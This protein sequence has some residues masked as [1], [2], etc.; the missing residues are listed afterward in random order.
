MLLSDV[1]LKDL[2]PHRGQ[3]LLVDE[4]VEVDADQAL[5][6]FVPSR[7]WP[8][9]GEKGVHPIV[10]VELA[11]QT[12]GVCNGWDRVQ[13]RGID[14]DKTGWLVGVKKAEFFIASLPF[15]RAILVSAENKYNF[16]NLREVACEMHLDGIAG[17]LAGRA[18]LQLFQ[19]D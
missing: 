14:S 15:D 11:A 1:Q 8:L 2:L 3:M 16:G 7:S 9:A 5:A 6:R 10:L 13:S 19:A 18:T 4:I 12:A 17:E